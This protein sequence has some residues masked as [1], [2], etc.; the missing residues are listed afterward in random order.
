M[1]WRSTSTRLRTCRANSGIPMQRP[2]RWDVPCSRPF[3]FILS[4]NGPLSGR[5]RAECYVLRPGPHISALLKGGLDQPYSVTDTPTYWLPRDRDGAFP[6]GALTPIR[7][8]LF[9]LPTQAVEIGIDNR[10]RD[11]AIPKFA[12]DPIAR[13]P[14]DDDRL[15]KSVGCFGFPRKKVRVGAKD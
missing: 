14:V 1:R 2:N 11:S 10:F 8:Q 6:A 5:R 4:Y 3:Q 7:P 12:P 9:H 15:N 13:T